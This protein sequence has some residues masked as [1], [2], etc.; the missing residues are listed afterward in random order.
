[1]T[2][3]NRL[4]QFGESVFATWSRIAIENDAINLGQGF[5]DFDAPEFVKEAAIKAIRD[6]ENQYSRSAGHPLLVQAIADTFEF[7]VDPMEEVTVSCGSTESIS[8]V[9]LGIIN[10][11]DEVIVIEPFYDSYTACLAM[12]GATVKMVTLHA[13]N[14]TLDEVE[15]RAAFTDKTKMIIINTPHNPTGRVFTKEEL[16]LIAELAIKHNALV[17][18]DEVYDKLVLSGKHIPIATLPEMQQ[19]TITL[20]SL[21]K[22]FS[23]TGWKIGWAVAPPQLT[24]GIRCA[25]QFTT[26]CAATPLQVA[27]AT[28]LRA[29]KSYYDSYTEE[30]RQRR[31]LLV[32]GLLAVGFNV[33]SPEGTYFVLADHTPFGF[34]DDISFCHHLAKQ[35]KVVGIPPSAFYAQSNDGQGLVRFAFCKGLETL[36]TAVQR[37]QSLG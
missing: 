19:R 31:D 26:F 3:A 22:V 34:E 37:L 17:L 12:V 6:G 24:E 32:E 33:H 20:R 36:K 16:S 18:S 13:P 4:E 10:P 11:G 14:F 5:P 28:A 1:M 23:V 8:N 30:Y 2:T 15:L 9:I 35:C 21:G 29:P 27:A 25:H 7:P